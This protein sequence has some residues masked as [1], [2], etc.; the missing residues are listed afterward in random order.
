VTVDVRNAGEVAGAAGRTADK[1]RALGYRVGYVGDFKPQRPDGIV[2][3]APG[4][5]KE[6]HQVAAD[7]GL[8]AEPV[9]GRVSMRSGSHVLVL[10]GNGEPGR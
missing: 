4:K 2:Y 7:L 5:E 10:L 1:L 8:G 6:G 3:F 9:P